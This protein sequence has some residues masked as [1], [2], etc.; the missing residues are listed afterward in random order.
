M[1]DELTRRISQKVD[2]KEAFGFSVRID[3]GDTGV[4][5]IAGGNAPIEVSNDD[6]TAEAAF[7]LSA[8]DLDAM[9]AGDLAPMNAYILGKLR[10][11]GDLGKAMQIGDLFS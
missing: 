8:A 3:L 9:L 7:V 11:E 10:V 5:F 4:I 2:G 6:A 1:L